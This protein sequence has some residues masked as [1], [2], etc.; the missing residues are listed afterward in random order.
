MAAQPEAPFGA[1]LTLEGVSLQLATITASLPPLPAAQEQQQQPSD[2]PE[3]WPPPLP[4]RRA[5]LQAALA[6]VRRLATPAL[7]FAA[8]AAGDDA[9][10]VVCP[11]PQT[12]N[13]FKLLRTQQAALGITLGEVKAAVSLQPLPDPDLEAACSTGLSAALLHRDWHRL[14]EGRLLGASPLAPA[15]DGAAQVCGS[16]TLRVAAVPGHATR[17]RLLVRAGGCR[18]GVSVCCLVDAA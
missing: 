2:E 13:V 15:A 1:A 6:A 12:A 9:V 4:P 10:R 14:G 3:L 5:Q 8:L 16:L 7:P 11:K 18:E 17:L